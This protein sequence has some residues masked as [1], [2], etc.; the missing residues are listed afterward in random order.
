ME[1]GNLKESQVAMRRAQA[2]NPTYSDAHYF[3]GKVLL[4]DGKTSEALA[5]FE[6]EVDPQERLP[7]LAL[8]Y[9]ALGRSD[10]ADAALR[11]ME[12]AVVSGTPGAMV[13]AETYAYRGDTDRAFVWLTRSCE[14]REPDCTSIKLNP[15]L[16]NLRADPRF[17]A[18]LRKLKLPE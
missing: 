8:A 4:L 2:L 7:G 1:A 11:S 17:K 5:E 14:R 15:M 16:K 3:L 10:D 6:R 12:L 13:I 18:L 9:H